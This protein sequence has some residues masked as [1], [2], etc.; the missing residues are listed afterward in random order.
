MQLGLLGCGDDII[1][2]EL[3]F[4]VSIADV[5]CNT[6]VEQNWLLR[7]DPNLRAQESNVDPSR[8]M[9]INELIDKEQ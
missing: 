9:A 7:D 8:V 5:F 4:I 2:A 6:A 1:H 3:S